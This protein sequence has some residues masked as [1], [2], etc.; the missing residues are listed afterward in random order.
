MNFSYVNLPKIPDE[1]VPHCLANIPMAWTDPKLIEL[2]KKEGVSHSIT[3]L[4]LEIKIW[5][6]KNII[7]V[8]DPRGIHKEL[9]SK[10]FLHIN[11]YIDHLEGKGVHPI[12]VDYG[13]QYAFNYLLT[14]GSDKLPITTWYEDDKE[15]VI[16]C[17]KI[18]VNRWHLI[19]VNPVWHGVKGQDEGKYRTIV[20]LCYDP[21]AEEDVWQ[22]FQH[23]IL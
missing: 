8:I 13:R 16:E 1:F 2:N 11:E 15:T 20:S 5:L 10:M 23:L 4:P 6:L 3:H 18:E 14:S 9:H 17:H 7:P 12:H 19:R 22:T 21:A